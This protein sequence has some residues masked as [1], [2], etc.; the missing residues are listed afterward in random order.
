MLPGSPL[1]SNFRLLRTILYTSGARA[2]LLALIHSAA[3]AGGGFAACR[4]LPCRAYRAAASPLTLFATTKTHAHLGG[5]GRQTS[6]RGG[7]SGGGL[8]A[9]RRCLLI[10]K[11]DDEPPRAPRRASRSRLA[12]PAV[13]VPILP[14]WCVRSYS[15]PP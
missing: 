9:S 4:S 11:L 1:Y 3:C 5:V 15:P 13:G 12:T 2:A 10:S 8:L 14:R 6:C 7:A